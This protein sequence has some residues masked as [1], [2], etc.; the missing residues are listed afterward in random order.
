MFLHYD[1][2]G[3]LA[4]HFQKDRT[5]TSP[6]N[7]PEYTYEKRDGL[8]YA[9]VIPPSGAKRDPE[10]GPIGRKSRKEAAQDAA[11]LCLLRLLLHESKYRVIALRNILQNSR[12]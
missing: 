10:S 5:L 12:D 9:T 4:Q 11:H 7:I 1:Y 3:I 2:K 8:F 6:F